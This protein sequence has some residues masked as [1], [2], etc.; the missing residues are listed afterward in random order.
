M[1][2]EQQ[3]E[4]LKEKSL[5]RLTLW[6]RR[7][8]SGKRI[9]V[10]CDSMRDIALFR[11]SVT[12]GPGQKRIERMTTRRVEQVTRLKAKG[13]NSWVLLPG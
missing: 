4:S 1:E 3:G 5:L 2:N 13:E 11:P 6:E 12:S 9:M 8:R 7:A 10:S